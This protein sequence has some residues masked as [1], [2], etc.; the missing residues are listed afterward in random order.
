[1]RPLL[2]ATVLTFLLAAC[3]TLPR[4]D[5][6]SAETGIDGMARRITPTSADSSCVGQPRTPICA[7]ETLLAC[8]FQRNADLCAVA[9]P[10]DARQSPAIHFAQSGTAVDYV[11][12][13]VHPVQ[14]QDIAP[15]LKTADWIKVGDVEVIVVEWT[16]P[17]SNDTC[18]GGPSDVFSYYA[19]PS[20]TTWFLTSWSAWGGPD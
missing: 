19:R 15:D 10:A 3:A 2:A 7:V 13:G 11:V 4:Q 1:M 9:T 17:A 12:T 6:D 16:C 14:E 8:F 5:R 18:L 20:G